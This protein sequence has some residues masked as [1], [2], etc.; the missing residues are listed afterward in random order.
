MSLSL[1][2]PL[3]SRPLS[4][5]VPA[6]SERPATPANSTLRHSVSVYKY[7]RDARASSYQDALERG[8]S[9]SGRNEQNTSF[10]YGVAF[11]VGPFVI[12]TGFNLVLYGITIMQT[13]QYSLTCKRYSRLS[14]HLLKSLLTKTR[15]YAQ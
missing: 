13:F 3:Q 9:V 5:H 8:V 4:P 2:S 14:N 11:S 12:G 15:L 6:R 1:F 7:E 10:I